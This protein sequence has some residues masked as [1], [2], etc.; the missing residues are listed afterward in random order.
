ML[1]THYRH[2]IL[3]AEIMEKLTMDELEAELNGSN[4]QAALVERTSC[5]GGD[6][7]NRI[8]V[9]VSMWFFAFIT[10]PHCSNAST[11]NPMLVSGEYFL[12]QV[13]AQLCCLGPS[14]RRLFALK[15]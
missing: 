1:Q 14:L 11:L 3:F 2:H 12:L 4:N 13:V 9:A 6:Q 7:E 8:C 15:L 5:R 10:C